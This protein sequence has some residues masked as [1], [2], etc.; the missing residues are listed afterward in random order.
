MGVTKVHP[1]W[2]LDP[3]ENAQ[4]EA[5]MVGVKQTYTKPFVGQ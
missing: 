4:A 1:A 5:E 3:V 2:T